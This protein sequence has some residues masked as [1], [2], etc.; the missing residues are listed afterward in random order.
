MPQK[1][2]SKRYLSIQSSYLPTQDRSTWR[3]TTNSEFWWCVSCR[4]HYK[5]KLCCNRKK[6]EFP[7]A[8]T[9]WERPS[10]VINC[11]RIKQRLLNG[12]EGR[13]KFF[14]HEKCM[15]HALYMHAYQAAPHHAYRRQKNVQLTI[16]LTYTCKEL[17]TGHSRIHAYTHVF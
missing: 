8:S 2:Q 17:C 4:Y 1:R 12:N 13:F 6:C 16:V 3:D 11:D 5:L 9:Q 10:S 7:C 15:H 14:S